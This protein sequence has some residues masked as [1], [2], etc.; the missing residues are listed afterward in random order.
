MAFASLE[1]WLRWQEGL[2]SAQIDLGLERITPIARRLGLQ[3][4]DALRIVI[5]GTNG[6]GSCAAFLRQI[7]GRAG[8]R[9]G[10]YTSPHLLNYNER[11]VRLGQAAPD[12]E[13]CAAFEAVNAQRADVPLTYFEFGTLAALQIFANH[14]LH[15]QIL[16]VGLGG[17]LDAVN[18]V[19]A[20]CT[21]ITPI[22]IDHE[23]WLGTSRERI[24]EEKAPTMRAGAPAVLAEIDPPRTLLAYAE[25]LGACTVRAGIDYQWRDGQDVWHWQW[26]HAT[27]RRLPKPALPGRHQLDNAAAAVATV[28]ILQDKLAVPASAIEHGVASAQLLGRAT[29][30]PGEVETILDVAHNP[31]GTRALAEFL[32]TSASGGKTRAVIGMMHDKPH[33]ETIA[34]LASQVDSWYVCELPDQRALGAAELAYLVQATTQAPAHCHASVAEAYGSSRNSSYPGDRILVCGSFVTVAEA[35]NTVPELSEFASALNG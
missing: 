7:Y 8:W 18:L 15:V 13:I 11:I 33:R 30:V 4:S 23:A 35:F 24:A 27:S 1:E 28:Q 6:K 10:V 32:A 14:A 12:E 3:R 19:D 9:V 29:S 17:R 22:S 31:A 34:A 5:A 21:L 20:D 25:Q 26:Q 2:H 16:E